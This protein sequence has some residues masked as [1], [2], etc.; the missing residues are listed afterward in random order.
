MAFL[1]GENT[2]ATAASTPA[3]PASRRLGWI[4]LALLALIL[5]SLVALLALGIDLPQAIAIVGVAGIVTA[6]VRRRL[7]QP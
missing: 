5:G 7:T 1:L 4:D 2:T 6:E 3:T